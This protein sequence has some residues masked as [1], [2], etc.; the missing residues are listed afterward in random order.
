[1]LEADGEASFPCI[2]KPGLSMHMKKIISRVHF[3]VTV[4]ACKQQV[5]HGL[6]LLAQE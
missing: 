1:M 5:L 6:L 3:Q 4:T 2:A